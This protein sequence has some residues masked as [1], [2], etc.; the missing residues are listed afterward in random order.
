MVDRRRALAGAL[1]I[2]AVIVIGV[3]AA[4]TTRRPSVTPA[5]SP[6]PT[7]AASIGQAAS[8]TPRT[9]PIELA[10]PDG[11]PRPDADA[12]AD[13]GDTEADLGAADHWRPARRLRRVPAAGER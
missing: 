10:R 2:A 4:A 12:H 11:H 9:S 1:V 3:L 7:F 13:R 5:P 8:G 6:E